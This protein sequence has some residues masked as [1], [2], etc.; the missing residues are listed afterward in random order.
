MSARRSRTDH[1]IIASAI[2][3]MITSKGPGHM[4]EDPWRAYLT[5]VSSGTISEDECRYI[6]YILS[7]GSEMKS[8]IESAA[9]D[10][11]AAAECV[12]A[13]ARRCR[14][15]AS[16]ISNIGAAFAEVYSPEKACR[17]NE[18]RESGFREFCEKTWYGEWSTSLTWDAGQCEL[19]CSGNAGISFRIADAERA[20]NMLSKELD[21]NPFMTADAIFGIV[22]DKLS[23]F[24]DDSFGDYCSSDDYY[25]PCVEDF[26]CEDYAADFCDGNGLE[27]V[28]CEY[29]G[30]TGNY[31][32]K[33]IG[34]G[35]GKY[36]PS[37]K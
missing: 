29:E 22:W 3:D 35:Y 4:W 18:E 33:F 19:G 9:A 37:I 25:P 17:R 2:N 23:S 1:S 36:R 20:R 7:F 31:E 5:L 32:P 27:V 21:R 11:E 15:S 8:I 13:I 16:V 24:L 34:T 28:K 10:G 6:M 14:L 12:K 30:E 26:Q